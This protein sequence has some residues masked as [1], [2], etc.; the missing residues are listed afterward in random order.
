MGCM[1]SSPMKCDRTIMVFLNMSN[2]FS[3]FGF[4]LNGL[5]HGLLQIYFCRI[6]MIFYILQ[7]LHGI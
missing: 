4:D 6:R 2:S 5:S 3:V 1:D 7:Y